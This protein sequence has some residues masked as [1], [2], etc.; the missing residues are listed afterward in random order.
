M[1]SE[2]LGLPLEYQQYP[3]YFDIP[4]ANNTHEKNKVVEQLLAQYRVKTV[5]DMTCGTGAQVLYLAK[6]GYHV[7]GSDFSPGLIEIAK[8]KAFKQHLN[9]TFITGDMRDVQLGEF[10]AV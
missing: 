2:E 5:L 1:K 6:H 9:V 4:S 3:E 7:L 10:D 8:E